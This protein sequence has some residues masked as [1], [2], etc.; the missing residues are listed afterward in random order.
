[1]SLQH[2]LLGAALSCFSAGTVLAWVLRKRPLRVNLAAHGL[3]VLGCLAAGLCA[4]LILYSQETLTTSAIAFP[5]GDIYLR[6]DPLSA[7]F[8]L[9]LGIVGTAVSIYAGAYTRGYYAKEYSLLAGLFNLFLLSMTLVFSV[10]H[11]AGFLIAWEMMAIISFLLVNHE[12]EKP[13]IRRAAFVYVVMTHI[14]TA[15][16]II[17]FLLMG[18]AAESLDFAKLSGVALDPVTRNMVFICTLIGFGAKAGIV[19]LHIWL[20]RAYPAAPSHA[21]ALMS[22]V[23]IKT[24]VYGLCRFFLEFLGPGPVWWGYTILLLAAVTAF[25]GVLWAL[26]ENDLKKL[27]AYSSVENI[28]IIL[29]GVGAG[30][31]FAAREQAALAALAWTAVLYHSLNHAIFKSLLFLVAGSILKGTHTSNLERLGGLIRTMPFTAALFFVGAVSIGALPPLNGFVSEWLTLQ[32]L[33]FLP[34]AIPGTLGRLAGVMITALLGLTGA[35]AAACFVKAF[36][37]ACLGKPRSHQSEQAKEVSLAMRL[38]IGVLAICC[39]ALGIWPQAVIGVLQKVLTGFTAVHPSI[40]TDSWQAAVFQSGALAAPLGTASLLGILAVALLVAF[41]LYRV[42]GH[43]TVTAGETWTCGITPSSRMQYS[44]LGFSKPVRRAFGAILQPQ[45]EILADSNTNLYFGRKLTFRSKIEYL[46]SETLYY[47]LKWEIL[48]LS[49][50]M[51]RL[52]V[53]NVQVYI[54]YI[55]AATIVALLWSAGWQS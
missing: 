18:R 30:L 34:Q 10:A 29:F 24:A 54:A 8:L 50:K 40:S 32:S 6:L 4:L 13:E 53:G 51:K 26:M 55:M 38:P 45:R 35:L 49:A 22:G 21:A 14:G 23:M 12:H 1:M 20:P 17:A 36:G 25:L 15:F 7:W 33:F 52:Q 2:W 19:P 28:G 47:P 31:V 27:L 42:F 9:L 46:L 37:I 43:S 5:L 48:H 44:S 41:C 16:L 3:A 39:V 11:V